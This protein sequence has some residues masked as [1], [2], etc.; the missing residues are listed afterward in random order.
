MEWEILGVVDGTG[1]WVVVAYLPSENRYK[2]KYYERSQY[3][4]ELSAYT[5][6]LK[7]LKKLEDLRKEIPHVPNTRT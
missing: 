4:D 3:P 2:H 1:G 7:V 6:A 5:S